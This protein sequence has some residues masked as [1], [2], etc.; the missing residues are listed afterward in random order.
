MVRF[1]HTGDIHLGLQFKNVS[2]DKE[3]AR[4]RREELWST[5]QGIVDYSI[6]REMDFLLIAGDLFEDKYFTL[7]DIKRLGDILSEA[8]KV[9][10]IIVA[11]NHDYLGRNSL[12]KQIDW[13]PNITIF[14]SSGI[15]YKDFPELETR[16][17][18]YSWDRVEI[19][20]ESILDGI[21][22]EEDDYKRIMILHGDV[23]SSSNY[24][25]LN[26][27][28]LKSLNMDYIALGHIH[29]PEILDYNIAYCG[30]PE[31]LNFGELGQRGFI[32]GSI[33]KGSTSIE[34]IPFSKRRF[35]ELE[36]EID[37]SMGYHHIY[38]KIRSLDIGKKDE[39]FYR[40]KLNGYIENGLDLSNLNDSLRD[41]F[42][43]LEIIDNTSPDY[44]L[45]DLE[46]HHRD[47]IIGMFIR[48]MKSQGLEDPLV[49]DSL[50]MGLEAL[51][52][53]RLF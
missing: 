15:Q 34:F 14:N 6:D 45:E 36:L 22:E 16:V 49:R 5:F 33:S 2:F 46:N 18:G 23:S 38:N 40:I 32:E 21:H 52:K 1:L 19:K 42:Y 35:I 31:P 28:K 4:L 26:I 9:N 11:G 53:G 51:L 41:N 27:N 29:K 37:A 50:Y 12:Y 17:Y 3:K 24:L 10:I 39:D 20:E 48:E 30:S 43:F 47:N 44:N 13:S 25:P 7:S 8:D